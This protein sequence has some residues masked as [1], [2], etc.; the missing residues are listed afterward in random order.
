MAI[1]FP[2]SPSTNQLYS[3]NGYYWKY[4]GTSWQSVGYVGSS[5]GLV[6]TVGTTAPSNPNINDVWIDTN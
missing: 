5:A 2:T 4:N 6:V 3:E 1:N